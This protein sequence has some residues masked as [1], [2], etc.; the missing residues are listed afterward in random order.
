[1]TI[2]IPNPAETTFGFVSGRFAL[3]VADTS[4][5]ED[6][7]PDFIPAAGSISFKP[8]T[9]KI[10]TAS[11][12][13]YI[14]PQTIV[15][16]LNNLGALS[17]ANNLDG[18]WMITGVYAVTLLVG[19][20]TKRSCRWTPTRCRRRNLTGLQSLTRRTSSRSHSA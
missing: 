4:R 16:T 6:H 14:V 20:Q 1:M 5:D 3:A 11:P 17:D 7:L 13:R 9:S 8:A 2:M 12:N 10:I 15:G 19:G 18:V